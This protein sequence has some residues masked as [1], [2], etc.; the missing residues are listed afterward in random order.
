MAGHAPPNYDCPF[1]GLIAGRDTEWNA[2]E[3]V[4]DRDSDTT[5][6]VCPKWWAAAPG[7]VVVIPNQHY[8]T[9]YDMPDPALGAVYAT[10]KRV[11]AALRAIGAC[12]GTSTRQHNERGGGQDVWHFH[13]HV[14]PR[15]DGDELYERNRETHW[16]SAAERAAV[17]RRIRTVMASSDRGDAC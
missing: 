6:F 8:E 7:H 12:Q 1:C 17:A 2:S 5:A 10:C 4:V 9:L 16:V 13:V 14:F 15:S 11:A 3:D